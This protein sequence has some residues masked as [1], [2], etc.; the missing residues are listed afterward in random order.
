LL[1]SGLNNSGIG[2]AL[3]GSHLCRENNSG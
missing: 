1:S 2:R 3:S